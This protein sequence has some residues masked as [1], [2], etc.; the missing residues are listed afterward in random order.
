MKQIIDPDKDKGIGENQLLKENLFL[1]FLAVV[2][3]IPLIIVSRPGAGKSL[4]LQLIYNSIMGKY[5][6]EKLFI[7]Y[8][9]INQT[10]F[11]G[12]DSTALKDVEK[13]LKNRRLI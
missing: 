1:I 12:A 6:K 2:I 9:Q 7:N 8:P 13:L 4:G 11:Q 5:S 10:Y 3:K